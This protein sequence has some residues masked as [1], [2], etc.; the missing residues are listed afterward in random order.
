MIKVGILSFSDGR[1]RVHDNLAPY[2][3][4]CEQR[5]RIALEKTGEVETY[6]AGGIIYNAELAKEYSKTIAAMGI[7]AVIL[8]IPIFAFPNF[9]CIAASLQNIPI[10]AIAPVNGK[11]PGLGGLQAAV[12]MI[13]QVG[14]KCEKVWGNI[15]DEKTLSSIMVF[16]KAA[17]ASEELKGQVYGL[18]GGRSIGMGTG[19]VNPDLWMKRF[20]VDVEHIDQLEI[21]RR[22]ETIEDERANKAL[23]WLT[24][25]MGAIDYDGDK[26]TEESLKWQIKCYYAL[27]DLINERKLS[28]IGV[29]CHYELSE[30]YV[31]QCLAAAFFND[32]YD[33]DGPKEPMVYS[34]EADSDGALTMQ[35]M[36]LISGK[37]VLFFDFRHYDEKD[38]VFA[39]CNCGAMATWYAARSEDPK[40]NL[41]CVRLCPIIQKYAGKGC[42]VQYMAREGEATFCRLTRVLDQYKMTIFKGQFRSFP[43][44]KLEETCPSWPHGYVEVSADPYNLVE[45]Y[46][47][48]HVHGVY[49]DYITEL[50]K[51]CE[52]KEIIYEVII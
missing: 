31:T 47:N 26:L 42:H 36:K 2:I 34:C 4:E 12:N 11:L 49:G 19:T 28:F 10:L 1:K 27:K 50:K 17:Y 33:W 18:F 40:S 13:R 29:K 37:P 39:F 9:S 16:L 21:I 24:E 32:P 25:N 22:A 5:I 23:V 48:N 14:G 38:G 3:G 6:I 20:G 44:K 43:S 30:Y 52:L 7:H 8:N 51:F 15:E 41:K 35:I 46:E 45:K